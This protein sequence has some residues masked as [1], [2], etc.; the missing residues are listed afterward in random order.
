MGLAKSCGIDA[1]TTR[2][3]LVGARHAVAVKRFDR[4]GQTRLQAVSAHVA[5]RAAGEDYGY[6]QLAQLPRRL[7]PAEAIRSQQEQL[8][9]R[10]VLK[11]LI[12]NTEDHERAHALQRNADGQFLLSPAFGVVPSAQ[13]LGYQ[14]MLVGDQATQSTLVNALSPAHQF[15][16]KPGAARAVVKEVS[17]CVAGWKAAFIQAGVLARGVDMLAQ[18][19]DADRLQQQRKAFAE[20]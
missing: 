6:P 11:I 15:G 5:L 4:S 17:T 1:A 2:A 10:M 18:N 3:L 8:F 13:G 7:A 20:S 19:I 9:R 14:A 16:L 12:D